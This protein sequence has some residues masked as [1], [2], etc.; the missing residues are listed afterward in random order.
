M[1]P[2]AFAADINAGLIGMHEIRLGQFCLRPLPKGLQPIIG[3]LIEVET[4][5]TLTGICS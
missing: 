1:Q 3:I 5:P 2:V 4:E